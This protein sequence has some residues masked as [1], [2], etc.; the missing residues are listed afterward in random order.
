M[1]DEKDEKNV[2]EGKKEEKK[3]IFN[4]WTENYITMSKIWEDSYIKLYKLWIESSGK[5][6]DK[7]TEIPKDA[8]PQKYKE[9]YDEWT[10]IYQSTFNKFYP[11]ATPESNKKTL[12]KLLESAEKSNELYK[13]WIAQ[14]EENSQ[15]TKEMLQEDVDPAKYKECSDIWMKSYE[16]IFEEILTLPIME[17]TKEIFENYTGAPN[18]YLMNFVQMAQLWRDTYIKI[19][20]PWIEPVQKLYVKMAEISKGDPKPE[21]YKEF[22]TMW[23]DTYKETCGKDIQSMRPSKEIFESFIQSTNT[24]LDMY[25]SWITALEKMS[26]KAEELSKQTTDPEI[27]KEFYSLWIKMYEK[28]FE[29]FFEDMPVVGPMKELMEPTKNMAKIYADIFIKMSKIWIK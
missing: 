23:M 11:T 15:K 9:F 13:S 3:D 16:K 5:M 19:Y 29:S 14:L 10:K 28:A 6:F 8:A 24:Y 4:I 27:Y 25:R 2:G 20:G 18:I 12:E 21:T 17:S 22:Y 26:K 1:A 7:A